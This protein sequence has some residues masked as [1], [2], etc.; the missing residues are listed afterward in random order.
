ML[1][2]QK[3]VTLQMNQLSL[4][5]NWLKFQDFWQITNHFKRRNVRNIPQMNTRKRPGKKNRAC[6][7]VSLGNH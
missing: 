1:V 3:E 6:E 4:K 7:P 2:R 5:N